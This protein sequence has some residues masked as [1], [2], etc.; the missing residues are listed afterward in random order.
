MRKALEKLL[1]RTDVKME[2]QL[3]NIEEANHALALCREKEE[4]HG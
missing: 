3:A 1:D 4:D 2:T